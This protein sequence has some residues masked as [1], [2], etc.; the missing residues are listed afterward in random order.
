M[1]N[2][3]VAVSL[4]FVV[5]SVVLQAALFG[6]SRIQ[7]Y[8]ASPDL[9]LVVTIATVRYL[10]ADPALLVGFTAGLLKD[11]LGGSPLGLWAI[12]FTVVTYVTL[13]FR[14]RADEGPIAIGVGIFG[15][16]LAANAL[17][18]IVGTL[19]GQRFFSDSGVLKL[20]VLP[21]AYN[22]LL[23]ALLVPLATKLMRAPATRGWAT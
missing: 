2:R 19:F 3:N 1:R 20:I 6:D 17:F 23:A 21:S 10:D 18:T 4:A 22:I 13:R 9:I 7:P 14:R 11:L 15:L 5:T 12:A 8:G 16:S